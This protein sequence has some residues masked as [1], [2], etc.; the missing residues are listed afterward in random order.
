MRISN[1]SAAAL[2]LALAVGASLAGAPKNDVARQKSWMRSGKRSALASLESSVP[3]PIAGT[4]TYFC[5]ARAVR[6]L[7]EQGD[8]LWIGTEGGLFTYTIPGRTARPVAGPSSLGVRALA[9][10]DA[11]SLWV[12]SDY[13]VSV[14]TQA[15]WKHYPKESNTI[16]GRI[17]CLTP[18]ETRFWIGTYGNGCAYVMNDAVTVLTSQD[19]LPDDRVLSIA[20]ENPRTVYFGTAS[21]LVQG[22]SLGWKSLRYGAHLPIGA[23]KDM[24]FDE[25]EN[26]FLAIAEQGVSI[27]S[28]GRVRSFGAGD[29]LPG[30][31]VNAVDL[32]PTGKVWAVGNSGVSTFNG[33]E[34]T[35]LGLSI[36][37]LKKYRYASIKHDV[38]GTCFLGTDDGKVIVLPRD[39]LRIVS[40]P[41]SFP[42][43]RV[44]RI[45][46]SAAGLWFSTGRNIYQYKGSFVKAASPPDLY[47]GEISDVAALE[48]G[49]IWAAS[50]FGVLHYNGRAWETFDRTQGLPADHF[51]SVARD[52]AGNL[53]FQTFDRGIVEYSTGR[54]I[55]FNSRNGLPGDDIADLAIDGRGTPWVVTR[56]GAL[57][58]CVEGAWES[59]VLPALAAKAPDTSQAADSLLRIDPAIKFLPEAR[60][61]AAALAE[62]GEFRLGRDAAGS[63]IVATS[64]G[65]LHLVG[66]VWQG[67]E[68]PAWL[69]RPKPTAVLGSSRGEIWVG[70]DGNGV[71]VYR[72]GGWIRLTAS[73]GLSDD[74]IRA[75][76]EDEHKAI[77]IGTQFGGITRF[78]ASGGM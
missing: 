61:D 59:V 54:W 45:R 73:N 19:S 20:E 13:G 36:F 43:D 41:Q 35:A 2:V 18:G 1:R 78:E 50:R 31:E 12:G 64:R 74:D 53:W 66:A 3:R 56:T 21:G 75:L 26:L 52:P 46:S 69:Q 23:V 38:E 16:F 15:G 5:S 72:G 40:I 29:S 33:S 39:T 30:S 28:F 77:W 62:A 44:E 11:G 55:A 9:F 70:T 63:L 24:L 32:D 37:D 48:T 49:E 60:R 42:E 8:T 10:D 4:F 6:A 22:D 25:E 47:T 68:Y 67:I 51:V 71:L 57:A 17:R 65:V 14:R 34:W 58:R 27:Y 7:A 76:C